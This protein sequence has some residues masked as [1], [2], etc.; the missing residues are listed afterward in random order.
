MNLEYD[1]QGNP[2]RT[3]L[4][5]G[6]PGL[7]LST[8]SSYDRLNRRKDTAD[9]RSKTTLFEYNGRDDLT[10]VTDPRSLITEYPRNGL[11]EATALTSPDTGATQNTYDAAGNLKTRL[12]SRGV[13][14]SYSYD[15]LNRLSSV[16]YSHP[17]Q[18]SH[19]VTWNYDQTGAGFSNGIGR[20]TSTQFPGGSASYAYDPL[21]RMVSTTQAIATTTGTATLTTGYGYDSAGRITRIT[22]PSGR[23]LYITHS[24][25]I[26]TAL[27]IAPD[28]NAAALPL[29]TGLQF[30]PAPGGYG[31]AR[32]WQW[33]LSSGALAHERVFDVYG[34]IVRYPLG[35]AIRDISYDAAGRIRSYV[36]YNATSGVPVPQLDQYFGYD[37]LDRIISVNTSVD[38]WVYAYDDNGNRTLVSVTNAGGTSSRTHTIA[39]NSNRLLALDNPPRAL[40]QDAAGNTY[41]DL[42]GRIGWTGT[43]DLAGRLVQLNSSPDGSSAYVTRYTYNALE[44]RVLVTPV[45][46]SCIGAERQCAA[47]ST[48]RAAVVYVYDQQ[49]LLL[50]EYGSNG[51]PIREYVWLQG[52][53]LAVIDGAT[54]APTIFYIYADHIDTPR[55]VIDRQGRQRWNWLA[56]PFGNST[57]INNPLGFGAF[58]LNLRMPGQYWDRESGLVYHWHRTYDAGIGRYTQSDPIGLAGGINTYAYVEGNPVSKVDPD[59]LQSIIIAPR[60]IPIPVPGVTPRPLPMTRDPIPWGIPEPLSPSDREFCR[61]ERRACAELCEKAECDPDKKNIWG[62][63]IEKCIRG[64]LPAKCGGNGVGIS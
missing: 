33:Q 46:A 62:G 50:G 8:S 17:S 32:S 28:A 60:P 19:E 10:K 63:S 45:S 44:Q 24:S 7:N 27:S 43:H 9:P 4:A 1:A 42:Q 30:E 35:G 36:H 41:S 56:E 51:A 20:L 5:P 55:T 22:Y 16:V 52:T 11:G 38:A 25:G 61:R 37:E 23:V 59:G 47:I 2:T 57:P 49:G 29:V 14:A 31:P 3:T 64:C 26:P 53:P 54:T 40:A 12:D 34:R 18:A 48:R 6:V 15:A 13:L 58:D 39:A 21:G